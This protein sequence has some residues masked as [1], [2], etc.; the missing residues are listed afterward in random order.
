MKSSIGIT[1]LI[2][3]MALG[4]ITTPSQGAI[5]G[6][7]KS[8][9]EGFNVTVV[10]ALGHRR[11]FRLYGYATLQ[12][13][14]YR[15]ALG[16]RDLRYNLFV[17]PAAGSDTTNPCLAVVWKGLNAKESSNI[18]TRY[19]STWKA[20]S[21]VAE[22]WERLQEYQFGGDVPVNRV[23]YAPPA[24]I[25]TNS[26]SDDPATLARTVIVP[27]LEQGYQPPPK[28]GE[29]PGYRAKVFQNAGDLDHWLIEHGTQIDNVTMAVFTINGKDEVWFVYRQK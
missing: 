27:C 8:R 15:G 10:N 25:R 3:V 19:T 29:E 23:R 12:P 22:S 11:A 28:P 18:G 4:V 26:K 14:P 16:T 6:Y 13:A 9:I 2:V 17:F 5:D 24:T 1:L 20:L 7:Y 21:A